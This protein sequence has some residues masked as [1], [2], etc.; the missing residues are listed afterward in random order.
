MTRACY[1]QK[2]RGGLA[3]RAG[4][5]R[6]TSAARCIRPG[7]R[8]RSQT[9]GRCRKD[10]AFAERDVGYRAHGGRGPVGG[11]VRRRHPWAVLAVTRGCDDPR[12]VS[13]MEVSLARSRVDDT[14]AKGRCSRAGKPGRT[15]SSPVA[16][17]LRQEEGLDGREVGGRGRFRAEH[18]WAA[19][20]TCAPKMAG[21]VWSGHLRGWGIP[22]R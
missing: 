14:H 1:F 15:E 5:F 6:Q 4:V 3:T 22:V 7:S 18:G 10:W 16:R 2:H 13:V 19:R 21:N 9:R 12:R 8:R 17:T 11:R 20:G